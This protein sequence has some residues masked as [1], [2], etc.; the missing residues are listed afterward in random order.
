MVTF[1]FHLME[2]LTDCL[3]WLSG[4][5]GS[6][7]SGTQ[8]PAA[9]PP[10]EKTSDPD[11]GNNN[12]SL[13]QPDFSSTPSKSITCKFSGQPCKTTLPRMPLSLGLT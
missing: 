7:G 11:N 9:P 6:G 3:F 5:D 10:A 13:S 4:G 12:N 1:T 8:E 2:Q